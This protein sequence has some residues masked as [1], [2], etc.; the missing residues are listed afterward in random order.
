MRWADRTTLWR[1]LWLRAVQLPYQAVIQPDRMLSIVHLQKFVSVLDANPNFFSLLRLKRYCCTF[2][3]TLPVWVLSSSFIVCMVTVILF[4][5][6][7]FWTVKNITG[8][9]MVGLRW[10]NKNVLSFLSALGEFEAAGVRSKSRIFWLVLVMCPVIWVYFALVIMGVVLQGAN[11]YGYVRCKVGG[12]TSLK[13][14]A[15][16]Y[17]GQVT[18]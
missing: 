9:L 12:R 5:S 18:F 1:A 8:W 17:F 15:T 14:M 6:A 16:N 13:N 10:W 2:F 11:L 7:D 4:L 3:T